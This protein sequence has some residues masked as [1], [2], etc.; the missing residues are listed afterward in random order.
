MGILKSLL[1]AEEC[2]TFCEFAGM[3]DCHDVEML[4]RELLRKNR[5]IEEILADCKKGQQEKKKVAI[6]LGI[7][8]G[9]FLIILLI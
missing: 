2:R 6:S 4:C 8:G 5:R 9:L 1:P 3:A 7:L